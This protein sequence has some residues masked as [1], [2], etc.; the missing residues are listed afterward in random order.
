MVT[1]SKAQIWIRVLG[2]TL[3]WTM[4]KK[5]NRMYWK[6]WEIYKEVHPYLKDNTAW[7]EA[8]KQ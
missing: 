3:F 5:N 2:V 1:K 8:K 7:K 6:F 4:A